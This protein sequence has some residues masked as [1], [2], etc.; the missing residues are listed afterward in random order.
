MKQRPS[1]ETNQF[2][3]SQE[4]APFYGNQ[5]FITAFTSACHLSLSSAHTSGS[6]QVWGTRLYFVTWYIFTARSF[7]HPTQP[8]SWDT[9]PCQLTATAYSIYLQLPSIL[10]AIPPSTTWGCAMLCWQAPTYLGYIAFYDGF[11]VTNDSEDVLSVCIIN[12]TAFFLF[13]KFHS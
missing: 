2:S 7:L 12:T 1:W 10:E 6:I 9:T 11:I 13:D 3:A 5:S 4:I 8:L